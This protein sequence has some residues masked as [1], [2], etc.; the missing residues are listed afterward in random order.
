MTVE[1]GTAAIGAE[2]IRPGP[3]NLIT[4][5]PGLR[6][7]NAVDRE[8]GTGVTVLLPDQACVCAADVRGGAPGTQ[9]VSLIAPENIGGHID[10]LVF[11]GGSLFGLAA[12]AGVT[13]AL[14][15]SGRGTEFLGYTIPTVPSAIIFDLAAQRKSDWLAA[16]PYERLG[17]E[18]LAAVAQDFP[19]GSVG[20]GTGASA[21]SWAGGLG[22]ASAA[23]ED[24]V[25]VGALAVVNSFGEVA[26]PGARSFWAWPYEFGDEFGGLGA[27]D[28]PAPIALELT[29]PA[30]A[31]KPGMSTTLV[32]VATN[33]ALTQAE[34][35][36]LAIMA[37]DGM[38]RAIR[39]VHTLLDG[40]VVF[41]LGLGER[42]VGDALEQARLGALAAD[43]VARAIARAVWHA[44]PHPTLPAVREAWT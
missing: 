17:R 25:V 18:A 44:G 3:L 30:R 2:G 11:S 39:P 35:K 1:K 32:A 9:Q 27:P 28:L 14:G 19:L 6:V 12:A 36:R 23:R 13:S 37:Q 7:G 21:C 42:P 10:A 20:A 38:A 33:V 40:D 22:S 26:V 41:A 43:V 29:R 34:A 5:V 16:P 15:A 31:R 4:D 8:I 24:G